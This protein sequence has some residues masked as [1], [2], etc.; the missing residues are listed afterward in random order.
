MNRA[1][2]LVLS[3]ALVVGSPARRSTA[4]VETIKVD[5]VAGGGL[6]A[7]GDQGVSSTCVAWAVR[8]VAA[9][10][11]YRLAAGF[12]EPCTGTVRP[13]ALTALPWP[14]AA[15]PQLPPSV[16]YLY[17]A[18]LRKRASEEHPNGLTRA[19][20]EEWVQL[21]ERSVL[22][23]NV[24]PMIQALLEFGAPSES[25]APFNTSWMV[26]PNAAFRTSARSLRPEWQSAIASLPPTSLEGELA[27]RRRALVRM[28][29]DGPVIAVLS[30]YPDFVDCGFGGEY[31]PLDARVVDFPGHAV[32]IVAYDPLHVVVADG[33][34]SKP[35]FQLMNSWGTS[36]GE[37][38]F[39]WVSSDRLIGCKNG[40]WL[41]REFFPCPLPPPPSSD[42]L[43]SAATSTVQPIGF[44]TGS[45]WTEEWTPACGET[46]P[47]LPPPPP[48]ETGPVWDES[49]VEH[50]SRPSPSQT[51]VVKRVAGAQVTVLG[52]S[53]P[54]VPALAQTRVR[55]FVDGEDAADIDPSVTGYAFHFAGH[56][57]RAMKVVVPES[58][59]PAPA[60]PSTP[61]VRPGEKKS[62]PE[63]GKPP[64]APPL[65][66][67]GKPAKDGHFEVEDPCPVRPQDPGIG[68]DPD[69]IGGWIDRGILEIVDPENPCLAGGRDVVVTVEVYY[70]GECEA[71]ASRTYVLRIAK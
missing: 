16:T 42:A 18:R 67:D 28:L 48:S 6:P 57:G 22:F 58:A 34:V 66:P 59:R 3:L 40:A 47:P 30:M 49:P 46:S 62:P 35:C 54:L 10:N 52:P 31:A 39:T 26:K 15:D 8:T 43:E 64:P 36:W 32:V 70:P 23:P 2:I 24:A 69:V 44:S 37:N 4:G 13:P 61:A 68:P 7:V 14:S 53:V 29:C 55:Y 25:V 63:H 19:K 9:F 51:L 50:S 21:N 38:G 33:N 27:A 17:N 1:S 12:T 60:A 11:R 71:H 20:F 45:G 41:G 65:A 56:D 5:W